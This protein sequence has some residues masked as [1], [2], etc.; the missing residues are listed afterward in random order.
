MAEMTTAND[1]HQM[2]ASDEVHA[3]I[4]VRPTADF[5]AGQIFASTSV[6]L[7]ELAERL[8]ALIPLPSVLTVAIAEDATSSA[9]AATQLEQLGLT[10]VRWL[11][12]GYT[13]WVN[14]GLPTIAGWGVPGKDFGERLLIREAIPEI[15]ADEL[16]GR[17]KRGEHIV[18]LDSR[19]PG[20]FATSCIPGARSVP[21]G[22]LPLA[23]TDILAEESTGELSVVVNCAGRTRSIVGA[24]QLQRLG[25]PNVAALRNGTMGFTLAGHDLLMNTDPGSPPTY[26]ARATARAERIADEIATRDGVRVLSIQE[27]EQLRARADREAIYVVDV[28]MPHEFI[29]GHIPGALTCPGG[30][31]PFSDDQI[32]IHGATIVTVCDG[33]ARAIFAASLWRLMGFPRVAAL[34]GGVTAWSAAGLEIQEGGEDRPFIGGGTRTRQ[35]MIEYLAWEEALGEKYHGA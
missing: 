31:I 26:S 28:R 19:T 30:Q 22:E 8:P 7:P 17:L 24:F 1:L 12:G 4:D 14:A 10:R 23:I 27:L 13:E 16:A 9:R 35:Q 5:R 34:N 18:V 6:P 2:M 33:R 32:A 29:A 3:V 25:I 20:E 15:E 21:G 11:D